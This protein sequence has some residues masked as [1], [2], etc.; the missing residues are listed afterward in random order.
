[1]EGRFAR[2]WNSVKL[3]NTL[4][5]GVQKGVRKLPEITKGLGDG[6][7][8]LALS[9]KFSREI[10]KGTISPPSGKP[11]PMYLFKRRRIEEGRKVG[12]KKIP[13]SM[14]WPCL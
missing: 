14:K 10:I 3:K 11:P 8:R 4:A 12:E 13:H 7:M 6:G 1:M 5:S 9:W 2:Y